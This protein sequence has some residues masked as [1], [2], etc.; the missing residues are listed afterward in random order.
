MARRS[1]LYALM[2]AVFL[3]PQAAH[4]KT[5]AK[6]KKGAPAASKS[7][8]GELHSAGRSG[9][10]GPFVEAPDHQVFANILGFL[11]GT[12]TIGYEQALSDDNSFTA[13]LGFRSQGASNFNVTYLGL[14]GSYRWWLGQH[15]RLQGFYA[16]PLANASM[17]SVSYDSATV[18]GTTVTTKKESASSFIF[19]VGGEGGY[20]W[21][22]PAGFTLSAGLNAG[23]YFGSL[24]LGSGAPSIPFGGFGAG[25]N[26]TVGYAF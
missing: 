23:Y 7:A 17:V 24:S 19:G 12:P 3:L 26:G 5:K 8:T 18:S 13:Q 6:A 1:I 4:A 15:A 16:G 11:Y 10:L 20:Q 25:L 14:L 2:L 9:P 22:L 21:I